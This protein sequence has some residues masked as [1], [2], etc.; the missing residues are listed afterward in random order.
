[1]AGGL[2]QLETFSNTFFFYS[3]CDSDK[4]RGELHPA[5]RDDFEVMLPDLQRLV[6]KVGQAQA[7]APVEALFCRPAPD[8][9]DDL[10]GFE[11]CQRPS[12]VDQLP[13]HPIML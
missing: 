11:L 6:V 1:M 4:N 7:E 9:K 2:A 12:L 8:A 3:G 10:G 5:C 13:E